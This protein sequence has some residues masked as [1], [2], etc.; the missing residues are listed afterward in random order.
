[1]TYEQFLN[2]KRHLS[3]EYGF[4]A[5]FLP[6]FLFDF[7]KHIVTWALKKGR[8]A[9]FVDTGLGKT[10][11]QLVIAEN[12]VRKTNQPVLILTPLAVAFQFIAESKKIGIDSVAYSKDGKITAAIT[13]TNYERLHLFSADKFAAIILDESSILKNFEGAIKNEVTEFCKKMKYRFLSTANTTRIGTTLTATAGSTL[14]VVG[15]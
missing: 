7:Q 8:A 2:N 1:M 12:I 15:L 11:I 6:E 4:D 13:I 14:K 10:A 5:L 9:L 3:G